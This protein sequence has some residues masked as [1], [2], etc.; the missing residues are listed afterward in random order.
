MLSSVLICEKENI[1]T[2]DKSHIYIQFPNEYLK[3]ALLTNITT[4]IPLEKTKQ[5]ENKPD[6]QY[7]LKL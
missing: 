3:I 6:S 5:T 2:S 1:I 7:T 4:L